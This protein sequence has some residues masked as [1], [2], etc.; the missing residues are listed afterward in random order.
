MDLGLFVNI[1]GTVSF[2]IA[3]RVLRCHGIAADP[4]A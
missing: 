1:N 4:A 3:A 2:E